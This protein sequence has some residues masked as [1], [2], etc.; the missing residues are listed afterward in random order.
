VDHNR[1]ARVTRSLVMIPTRRDLLRGL[2]G[3]AFG[4]DA[5]RRPGMVAAQAMP[6]DL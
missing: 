4:R 5:A 1:F 2:A 3:A 6:H